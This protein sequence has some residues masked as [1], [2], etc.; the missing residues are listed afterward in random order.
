MS[1]GSEANFELGMKVNL[2]STASLLEALRLVKTEDSKPL[3][4]LYAS[5]QAVYGKPLPTIIDESVFPTPEGSYG[6]Q[7]LIIETLLNDYTRKGFLDGY[8]LRFPTIAIRGGR[9]TQAASS[10]ISGMIREPMNGEVCVIPIEDRSFISWICSPKMLVQNLWHALH[11]GADALPRHKRVV[12]L[13]G[14]GVTVQEMRDV[15]AK[16]GGEDK[17]KLLKEKSDPEMERI[18]RSWGTDFDNS[19][20][21]GLGFKRDEGF[22][23]VVRDYV[24]GLEK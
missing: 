11:L 4:V 13:P 21:L 7:K 1:S 19:L 10:F 14:F 8:S 18:L 12:N 17:L 24:N 3:R 6:A 2:H 9:P 22:E 20:G 5:S 16:V 23:E 15:L